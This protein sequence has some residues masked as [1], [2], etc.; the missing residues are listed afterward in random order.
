VQAHQPD[1]PV[2]YSMQHY[3]R[4][5]L[6]VQLL[7][8]RPVASRFVAH[9]VDVAVAKSTA[10]RSSYGLLESWECSLTHGS[11][12]KLL[13]LLQILAF[14]RAAYNV[15]KV[16]EL[17]NSKINS[18]VHHFAKSLEVF[19]GNVKEENLGAGDVGAP[20]ELVCLVAAYDENVALVNHHDLSFANFLLKNLE[21]CPLQSFEVV[22]GMLVQFCKVK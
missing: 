9:C 1:P 19:G 13:A 8:R 7:N 15:H 11:D 10:V 16:F 2:N 21:T 5:P 12:F 4:V 22:K 17:S 6:H 20:V 18:I 14:E 3:P